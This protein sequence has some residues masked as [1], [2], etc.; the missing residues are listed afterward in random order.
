MASRTLPPLELDGRQLGVDCLRALR[1][2]WGN[3]DVSKTP[4]DL[5]GE[6]LIQH[7]PEVLRR[8]LEAARK[9]G[10]ECERGFLCVLSDFLGG[11]LQ[12]PGGE[13]IY[14]ARRYEQ[15]FPTRDQ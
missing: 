7:E 15:H 6:E 2:D 1:H 5:I 14:L 13:D 12:D 3:I 8:Y 10:P 11:L 9:A 4:E